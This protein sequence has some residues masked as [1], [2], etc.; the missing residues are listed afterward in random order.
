MKSRSKVNFLYLIPMA[1]IACE[2]APSLQGLQEWTPSDHDQ[3]SAQT[4]PAP[5]DPHSPGSSPHGSASPHDSTMD[6]T[7]L[8]TLLWKQ[9]CASCHG[10]TGLGDGPAAIAT[11]PPSL[12]SADWQKAITD[13]QIAKMITTGKGKMPK[14]DLPEVVVKALVIHIRTLGPVKPPSEGAKPSL[15]R[16]DK[17]K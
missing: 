12:A 10:A 13:A 7:A 6:T 5:P 1:V 3:Q 9:Q 14:F 8:T 11:R 15:G 2:R 17:P 16:K 4:P